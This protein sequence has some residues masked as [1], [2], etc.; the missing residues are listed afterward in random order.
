M[1]SSVSTGIF[2]TSAWSSCRRDRT[3]A[4]FPWPASSQLGFAA[5][6]GASGAGGTIAQAGRPF[7]LPAEVREH[8]DPVRCASGRP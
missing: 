1:K 3:R 6:Q 8:A 4:A 7:A 5:D 2:I